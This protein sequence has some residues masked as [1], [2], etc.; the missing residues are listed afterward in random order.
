MQ[1]TW[2]NVIE[3]TRQMIDARIAYWLNENL[4][5]FGWWVLL[6]TT[7]GFLI[8]WVI[9]LDKK[10][11]FEIITYGLIVEVIAIVAD[12]LGIFLSLWDYS[13]SLSP[14][15][16]ILEIHTVQMPVIYMMIY[17]YFKTWKA[18]LIA[19]AMNA[20]VFAFILEP[21]LV[22]LQIYELH[23]WKHIYSLVPYFLIAVVLKWIINQ[24]KR[25]DENYQ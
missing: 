2:Q 22:W 7:L 24:F 17:Q 1:P 16:Q 14:I 18:F 20:F 23:H 13:N 10:R 3:T 25:L 4:F 12:T 11:V 5:T 8:V 6:V 15:P 21:L 19:T 9:I